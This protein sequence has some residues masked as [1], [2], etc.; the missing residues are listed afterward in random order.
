MRDTG[1]GRDILVLIG[2]FR[3]AK[4]LLLIAAAIGTLR[5]ERSG[6]IQAV[7]R[8]ASDLPLAPG[9]ALLIRAAEKIADLPPNR[10]EL[11]AIG[12]F[13]Y[14]TLFTFEGVGLILRRVWAEYLAIV[15]TT[16]F[17]PLEI[18]EVVKRVSPIRIGFLAVNIAIV[19]YLIWRRR[20]QRHE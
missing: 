11:V 2:A 12:L 14:A 5:L 20:T 10:I 1:R 6:M 17:I 3:L 16:S 15:A 8:W 9:R 18:Y 19:I 4:A 13:A 7:A